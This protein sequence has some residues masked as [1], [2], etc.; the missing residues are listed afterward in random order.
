MKRSGQKIATLLMLM[1]LLMVTLMMIMLVVVEIFWK[2]QSPVK[3][4]VT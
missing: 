1:M 4:T 3:S 2:I